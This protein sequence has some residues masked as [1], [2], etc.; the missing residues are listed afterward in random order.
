MIWGC[1]EITTVKYTLSTRI[2]STSEALLKEKQRTS[3]TVIR[4]N[5][6]NLHAARIRHFS[7]GL[8]LEIDNPFGVYSELL[9][10][11]ITRRSTAID[12][13]VTPG[14]AQADVVIAVEV[15]EKVGITSFNSSVAKSIHG[16]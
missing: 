14:L 12:R 10:D 6:S 5:H 9:P 4:M 3:W 1:T 11:K 8:K 7:G 2:R 13:T 16:D 15:A